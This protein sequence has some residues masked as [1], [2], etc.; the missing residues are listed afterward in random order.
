MHTVLGRSLALAFSI[1]LPSA[2][3]AQGSILPAPCF[4]GEENARADLV[5]RPLTQVVRT[6]SAIKVRLDDGV[7]HYEITETFVNRGGGLAEADY[8]Y[9]LPNGAAFQD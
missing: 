9:P 7:L 1:G 5:C 6:S 8:I 4:R 3:A 2:L